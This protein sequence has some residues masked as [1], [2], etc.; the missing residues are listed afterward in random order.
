MRLITLL[1][2]LIICSSFAGCSW[3]EEEPLGEIK[4]PEKP[5]VLKYASVEEARLYRHK[6]SPSL[7]QHGVSGDHIIDG[8]KVEL[9]VSFD[10]TMPSSYIDVFIKSLEGEAKDVTEEG[11]IVIVPEHRFWEMVKDS[12]V[13]YVTLEKNQKLMR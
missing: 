11:T 12:K 7:Y 5:N 2:C 6:I 10:K 13:V 3:L 9:L 4:R 8:Y 1:I